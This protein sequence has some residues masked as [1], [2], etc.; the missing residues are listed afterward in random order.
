MDIGVLGF[1]EQS[2]LEYFLECIYIE[3]NTRKELNPD[4]FCQFDGNQFP[5]AL[6]CHPSI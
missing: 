1:W 2:M 4:I 6:A 3:I 5:S